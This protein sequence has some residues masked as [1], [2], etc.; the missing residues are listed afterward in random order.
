MTEKKKYTTMSVTPQTLKILSRVARIKYMK[1]QAFMEFLANL[2]ANSLDLV[3][4]EDV[5]IAVLR[6]LHGNYEI[7]IASNGFGR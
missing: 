6:E 3:S 2:F 4:N 7:A 1:T 5:D